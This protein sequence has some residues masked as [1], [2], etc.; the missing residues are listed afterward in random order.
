MEVQASEYNN[1]WSVVDDDAVRKAMN[2]K[3][4]WM[5]KME[6]LQEEF[7]KYKTL[8]STWCS[9]DLE[10]EDSDYSQ[11]KEHVEL[12]KASLEETVK[13]VEKEDA[14]RN[15]YTLEKVSGSHIEYPKFSGKSSECFVKFK[16]KMERAFKAN[17][18]PKIDQVDKLRE[19][20]SGFALSLVPDTVKDI[21]V[22]FQ[23]L[24]DQWRDP[25]R[26]FHSPLREFR[27]LCK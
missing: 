12:A 7:M 10:D 5:K 6:N 26:V 15:L 9:E 18:V 13:S 19:N 11:L 3:Q 14:R 25:E 22:D 21:E 27:K 4:V 23:A 8:V 16:E 20:L 24:S 2:S 17:R 1:D